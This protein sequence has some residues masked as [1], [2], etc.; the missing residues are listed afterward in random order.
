MDDRSKIGEVGNATKNS[1]FGGTAKN[2]E[3]IK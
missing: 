1:K 3:K 2:N